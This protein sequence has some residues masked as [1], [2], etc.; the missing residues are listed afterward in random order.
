MLIQVFAA[1]SLPRIPVSRVR[2][3]VLAGGLVGISGA[4]ATEWLRARNAERSDYRKDLRSACADF[5]SSLVRMSHLA[6]ALSPVAETAPVTLKRLAALHEGARASFERLRL[7]GDSRQL[8]KAG[9]MAFDMFSA[10]RK[11]PPASR[12]P[13]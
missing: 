12:R 4:L 11:S 10:E 5:S 9:R 8:Q 3:V 7:L 6:W 1:D 13:L 2:L